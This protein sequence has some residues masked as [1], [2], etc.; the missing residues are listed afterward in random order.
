MFP[1]RRGAQVAALA[2]GWGALAWLGLRALPRPGGVALLA[3]AG[4]SAFLLVDALVVG[5]DPWGRTRS[6]GPRT[7]PL[8]AL[9]FDDGPGS[10]TPAILAALRDA[11]VKATFFVVGAQ[12]KARPSLVRAM[13]RDGHAVAPHTYSHRT[14]ALASPATIASEI[15]DCLEAIRACGVE[16]ARLFRAPRGW[17]GPLLRRAL[18]RRGLQLVA[19][20]RGAWDSEPR[21]PAEIAAAAARRPRPGD[22][23]LLHDGAATPGH[24][25]RRA[26]AA[27]IPLVVERYRRAGLGFATLPELFA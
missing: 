23:L 27:A 8:A 17:K 22:V 18:K 20:T 4:T 7:R 15:D 12:A 25:S 3:L 5:F 19:W 9:T 16:P 6:H 14:L 10:D 2:G 1:L 24:Q 11:G 13:A 21:S 26:T